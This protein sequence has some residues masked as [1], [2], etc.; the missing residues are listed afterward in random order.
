M[1]PITFWSQIKNEVYFPLI[2]PNTSSEGLHT[3]G[4]VPGTGCAGTKTQPLPSR[5]L[6]PGNLVQPCVVGVMVRTGSGAVGHRLGCRSGG[7]CGEVAARLR[8]GGVE[9]RQ[10]H[11]Q[12]RARPEVRMWVCSQSWSV[13]ASGQ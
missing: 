3:V 13:E 6:D 8:F 1:S 2:I 12:P 5:S 7:F 10:T 9:A 11:S 4:S